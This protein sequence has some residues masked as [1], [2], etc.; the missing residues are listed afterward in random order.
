MD[1]IL[2]DECLSPRLAAAACALFGI[3]L[4]VAERQDNRV[5]W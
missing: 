4:D 1:P 2:I 3:A 5:I